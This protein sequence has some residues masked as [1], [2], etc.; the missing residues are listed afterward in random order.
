VIY[1]ILARRRKSRLITLY[2]YGP[3]FGLPDAS[4][5]VMKAE[6]L[7]KL[8]ALPYEVNTR[9]FSKAPKG[10]LPYIRDGE[11]VIADSTLIR[12][13]LEKKHKFDFDAGLTAHDRGVAWSVEKM[14]EDHL[15]WHLVYWRWLVDENWE[16]GPK[17]FFKR[18]PAVIRPLVERMV[19]RNV[20]TRLH[21][22]GLGRHDDYEKTLLGNRAIEA[23]SQ[24]LGE[25]SYLMGDKPC[26]ADATAFA[27]VASALPDIFQSPIQEKLSRTGNLVAYRDRMMREFF[28]DFL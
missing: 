12:L 1:R 7:L 25:K 2:T 22:H 10:K 8:S 4:P 26:G 18:A 24:V 23:L 9:G 3:F 21:G 20:R 14:L 5:F 17:I 11:T 27:F 28:P 13:H 19:R 6:M 15:Y 16:R